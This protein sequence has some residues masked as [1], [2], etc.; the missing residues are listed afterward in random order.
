VYGSAVSDLP[1]LVNY[2]A[3]LPVLFQL[4]SIREPEVQAK[5]KGQLHQPP[6]I[7]IEMFTKD[8][9]RAAD[10]AQTVF[11]ASGMNLS[12]D[13][14][15]Q[16]RIKAKLPLSWALYTESLT[17]TEILGVLAR[18]NDADAKD[19]GH[20]VMGAV[21]VTVVGLQDTKEIQG[22][23]G[24]DATTSRKIKSAPFNVTDSTA[25]RV[26]N[27][28]TKA[29]GGTAIMATFLPAKLRVPVS[30]SRELKAFTERKAER[31]EGAIPLLIVLRA[32]NSPL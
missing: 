25:D 29:N 24:I 8:S 28:V 4:P 22:T 18:W 23:F 19:P 9:H 15:T 5:L 7:R 1:P 17:A 12:V 27:A 3:K 16:E 2:D 14:S 21:H 13:A 20:A 10:I 30:Q 26:A 6:A 32:M 11:R 31:K